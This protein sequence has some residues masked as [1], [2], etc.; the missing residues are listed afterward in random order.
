M[1]KVFP[2]E[3]DSKCIE[4]QLDA[5]HNQAGIDDDTKCKSVITG[6]HGDEWVK[7]ADEKV[8]AQSD[9]LVSLD[10]RAD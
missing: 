6:H 4:K 10:S 7:K 8:K 9:K 2:K 5:Y 3:C 1:E